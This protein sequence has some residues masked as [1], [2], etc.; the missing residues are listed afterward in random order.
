MPGLETPLQIIQQPLGQSVSIG[1]TATFTVVVVGSGVLA[2]QW[3][4]TDH[5]IALASGFHPLPGAEIDGFWTIVG[6]T[7]ASYT[8]PTLS[9][10]ENG[11]AFQCL[12]SNTLTT[13]Q[14][15]FSEAMT[16]PAVL[17]VH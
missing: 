7:S 6:A 17:L 15:L 4:T 5:D 9:A 10:S 3:Q 16:I 1:A 2:Y 14:I 13:P 8:T 11:A 12:I